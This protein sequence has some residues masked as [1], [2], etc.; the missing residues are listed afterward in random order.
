VRS[1]PNTAAWRPSA[2]IRAAVSRA[3]DSAIWLQ[4][5]WQRNRHKHVTDPIA[6]EGPWRW[7]ILGTYDWYSPR[8]QSKHTFPEVFGW[9]AEAGLENIQVHDWNICVSGRRPSRG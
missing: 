8:Y 4:R 7:K 9:F 1:K 6:G 3:H 5:Y 2:S